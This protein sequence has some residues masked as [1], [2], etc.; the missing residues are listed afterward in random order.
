MATSSSAAEFWPVGVREGIRDLPRVPVTPNDG[1][2]W[3]WIAVEGNVG[4]DKTRL[5]ERF[6]AMVDWRVHLIPEP[7]DAPWSASRLSRA[8]EDAATGAA[9]GPFL[10]LMKRFLHFQQIA[11]LE[12]A[13]AKEE[14]R[15]FLG[16]V[17]EHSPQSCVE[18]FGKVALQRGELRSSEYNLLRRYLLQLRE[19][20]RLPAVHVWLQAS[21]ELC[22]EHA[23]RLSGGTLGRMDRAYPPMF[24]EYLWDVEAAYEQFFADLERCAR[25]GLPDDSVAG[26]VVVRLD[27][28]WPEDK[29][30]AEFERQ[31]RP[32]WLAAIEG[33]V[34]NG[35]LL[36]PPEA[37]T[38]K[39]R[40]KTV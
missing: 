31:I 24:L 3:L 33:R 6:Q 9:E 4:A 22:T 26:V 15:P 20:G 14:D 1:R 39:V 18:V 27:A 30:C 40:S 21:A 38:E 13:A 32:I 28:T 34:D 36:V 17:S 5:L 35:V 11:S 12:A 10:S 8:N 25:S 23:A 37:G 29:L 7:T 16:V 2:S 19:E